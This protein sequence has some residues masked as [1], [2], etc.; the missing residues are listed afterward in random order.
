MTAMSPEDPSRDAGDRDRMSE[1]AL[2]DLILD[3]DE[4][5]AQVRTLGYVQEADALDAASLDLKG[6]IE[7]R[8]TEKGRPIVPDGG[9]D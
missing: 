1:R 8:L 4:I 9:G 2:F 7:L 6:Y 3:L 5:A